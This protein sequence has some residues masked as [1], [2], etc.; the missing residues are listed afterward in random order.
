MRTGAAEMASELTSGRVQG[1]EPALEEGSWWLWPS[2]CVPSVDCAPTEHTPGAA[3]DAGAGDCE[4]TGWFGFGEK[5]CVGTGTGTPFCNVRCV[6][7]AIGPGG[8]PLASGSGPEGGAEGRGTGPD[9]G[10]GCGGM[11][12]A[13][14]GGGTPTLTA[15]A[16]PPTPF[17][18]NGSGP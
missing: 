15:Y 5:G 2:V 7:L 16:R 17:A 9:C 11:R 13:S 4:A 18:E 8:A 12:Y 14:G 10:W 1:P 3:V 6:V